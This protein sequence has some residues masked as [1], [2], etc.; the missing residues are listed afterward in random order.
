M[1]PVPGCSHNLTYFVVLINIKYSMQLWFTFSLKY[2]QY[3]SHGTPYVAV[4]IKMWH[5]LWIILQSVLCCLKDKGQ[6]IR[7][8]KMNDISL[9]AL[10]RPIFHQSYFQS[11]Y[12]LNQSHNITTDCPCGA[13][14]RGLTNCLLCVGPLFGNLVLNDSW[15]VS[16]TYRKTHFL[17]FLSLFCICFYICPIIWWYYNTLLYIYL[18]FTSQIVFFLL[19]SIHVPSFPKDIVLTLSIT[20]NSYN[21]HKIIHVFL[22]SE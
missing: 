5:T 9:T 21:S 19:P 20:Q 10:Q 12:V 14:C 4:V 16:F 18:I 3:L 11:N 8:Y 15:F 6:I 22:F 17:L 2:K 7:Q 13:W 1:T